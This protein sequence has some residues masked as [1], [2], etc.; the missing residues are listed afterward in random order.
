MSCSCYILSTLYL[1]FITQKK[2]NLTCHVVY[3]SSNEAQNIWMFS[4]FLNIVI[5][6][7]THAHLIFLCKSTWKSAPKSYLKPRKIWVTIFLEKWKEIALAFHVLFILKPYVLI[8]ENVYMPGF[9]PGYISTNI[10][11]KICLNFHKRQVITT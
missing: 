9:E 6:L 1:C 3:G 5:N 2:V 4:H 11:T 7:R 10:S 8:L